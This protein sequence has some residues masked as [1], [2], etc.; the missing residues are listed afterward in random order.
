MDQQLAR[1][2]AHA[3][4]LVQEHP[5]LKLNPDGENES[6]FQGGTHRVLFGSFEDVPVVFKCFGPG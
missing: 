5:E 6:L 1:A 2:K 4:A 3:M